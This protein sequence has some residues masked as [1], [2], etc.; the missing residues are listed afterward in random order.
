MRVVRV[1]TVER[2]LMSSTA[3]PVLVPQA[4]PG[5]TVELVCTVKC[6]TGISCAFLAVTLD[7]TH[8]FV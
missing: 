2:V 5:T 4:T 8:I 3:S 6:Q 1:R 7:S